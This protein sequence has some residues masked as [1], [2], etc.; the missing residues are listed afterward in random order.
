MIFVFDSGTARSIGR[1][2]PVGQNP[3]L[4]VYDSPV[5]GENVVVVELE[6]GGLTESNVLHHFV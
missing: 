5:D 2:Q 3:S 4:T 6:L 1:T